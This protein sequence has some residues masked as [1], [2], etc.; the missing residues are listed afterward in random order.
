MPTSLHL[1]PWKLIFSTFGRPRGDVSTHLSLEESV[2]QNS[3][4]NFQNWDL[5][6]CSTNA[7][8]T[9]LYT[10]C[11]MVS[12]TRKLGNPLRAPTLRTPKSWGYHAVTSDRIPSAGAEVTEGRTGAVSPLSWHSQPAGDPGTELNPNPPSFL[13]EVGEGPVLWG[14]GGTQAGGGSRGAPRLRPRCT[15]PPDPAQLRHARSGRP[16]RTPARR[17]SHTPLPCRLLAGASGFPWSRFWT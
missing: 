17:A 11:L 1:G 16:G 15:F 13:Q 7:R 12:T 3:I 8:D 10:G 2:V 6:T 9:H 4:T 5:N 14:G